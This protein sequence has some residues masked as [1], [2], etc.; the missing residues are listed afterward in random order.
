MRITLPL[1]AVLLASAVHAAPPQPQPQPSV[2]YDII[3]SL[4]TEIGQRLAGTD[5]EAQARE[6]AVKRLKSLGFA[7][8]HVE[9]FDMPVWVRGV[10]TAEIVS[11]FP[12]KL[13]LT[14]LGN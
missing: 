8:V 13:M 4:T 9:P 3:E 1:A 10:E 14:A 11:P 5:A 2:G 12:Q 7:N 6:W